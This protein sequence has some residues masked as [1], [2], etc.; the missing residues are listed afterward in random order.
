MGNRHSANYG[1]QMPPCT[2]PGALRPVF[3]YPLSG[4]LKIVHVQVNKVFLPF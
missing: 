3:F 1:W 4:S 2:V